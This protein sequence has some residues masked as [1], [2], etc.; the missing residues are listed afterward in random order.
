MSIPIRSALYLL[1]SSHRYL[2]YIEFETEPGPFDK[3]YAPLGHV[4]EQS[5]ALTSD[6][7]LA[8]VL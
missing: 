6:A 3:S 2:K 5:N 7:L 8:E 1:Q 4:D